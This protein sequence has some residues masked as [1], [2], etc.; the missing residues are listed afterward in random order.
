MVRKYFISA[1]SKT[2]YKDG[3]ISD[4]FTHGLITIDY[5]ICDNDSIDAAAK[6]IAENLESKD[7]SVESVKVLITSFQLISTNPC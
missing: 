5:S 1:V 4:G 3:T 6:M 7:R 2:T